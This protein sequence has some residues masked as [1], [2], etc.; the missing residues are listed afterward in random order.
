VSEWCENGGIWRRI[1]EF[2][3][4]VKISSDNIYNRG[5]THCKTSHN[6]HQAKTARILA[7]LVKYERLRQMPVLSSSDGGIHSRCVR[8]DRIKVWG[9]LL[10]NLACCDVVVACQSDVR[11]TLIV[12]Q[13]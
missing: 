9:H 7:C 5:P 12:A 8:R 1:C 10:I 4:F 13:I 3:E 11:K 2:F 6:K